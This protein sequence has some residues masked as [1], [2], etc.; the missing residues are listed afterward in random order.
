VPTIA[1]DLLWRDRGVQRGL[2]GLGKNAKDAEGRLGS[3]E[4]LGPR[5]A[6][7]FAG[8][9]VADFLKDSI[10]AASDL[11]ETV[12]KS[13]AIFG[14]SSAQV[15][16]WGAGAATSM[17]LSK[18]A[19]LDSASSFG[20]LFLQLGFTQSK[21]LDLSEGTVQLA[22]DLGS[23]SNL[24]TADVLERISAGY[25]GEYDGLQKLIPN[26]SAA[27]VEQEALT[28]T[29]K[30]SAKEL[31]AQDKALAVNAILH[32]DGARAM[33]DFARTSGGLANQ[34][35]ILAAEFEN[36]KAEVGQQLLPVMM[37]LI[38]VGRDVGI[39]VLEG[40]ANVMGHIPTQAY[41]AGA[42]LVGL[43]GAIRV[44]SK[45]VET[46]KMGN[47]ALQTA[48]RLLGIR[49]GEAAAAQAVQTAASTTEAAANDA[50]AAAT[51]RLG[52]AMGALAKGA[53]GAGLFYAVT[54]LTGWVGGASAA[55]VETDKF[56]ASLKNLGAEGD[57]S[58][59]HVF[60]RVGFAGFS[61]DAQSSA[62]A[63][64]QFANSMNIAFGQGFIEKSNRLV[65]FG[66][67]AIRARADID[68]LDTGLAELA[69]TDMSSAM[70]QFAVLTQRM[71]DAGWSEGELT[72][73]FPH[74]TAAVAAAA[75]A[76]NAASTAIG[77]TG[78]VL[79]KAQ[80]EGTSA[81]AVFRQLAGAH[82][83]VAHT[84][85]AHGMTLKALL[86]LY[87][88]YKDT[89]LAAAGATSADKA[90]TVQLTAAQVRAVKAAVIQKSAL[91]ALTNA[92]DANKNADPAAARR[93]VGL[94]LVGARRSHGRAEAE[95]AHP[96]RPHGEGPREPAG[97][98][99]ARVRRPVLPR[100]DR[101]EQ[102]GRP[103]VPLHPGPAVAEA[104][105]RRPPVRR[106]ED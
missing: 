65:G 26:I 16:K 72:K 63:L 34:Q 74:Y 28:L 68:T 61:I 93:G 25:R 42:G 62:E 73:A 81:T 55:S 17:G 38:K 75:A 41:A 90:E 1:F 19:A 94:V 12:S 102:R 23:F 45:V 43:Y 76:S 18:R 50:A 60:N 47:E 11:N 104:V 78:S 31:T 58:F 99:P 91:D 77:Y 86:D 67:S 49:A 8:F 84:T 3:L 48:M 92:L 22:A 64:D 21:A 57:N 44:G 70:D 96:R 87:P 29:H 32:K 66:T 101:A 13:Q 27:R 85:V 69:K 36:T 4:K 2:Q 46:A 79:L 20:D 54:Q 106:D 53:V 82:T 10:S 71:R 6:G 51:T 89:V 88:K 14:S 9:E 95:R 98:R 100:S 35:R 37:T 30:S 80:S 15:E 56:A 7:A 105:R 24:D 97:P 40:I 59:R 39:P 5:L 83:S 103:E 52:G 33:G